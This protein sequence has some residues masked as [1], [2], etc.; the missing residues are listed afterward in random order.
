MTI[1]KHFDALTNR[2]LKVI[3]LRENSKVPMYRGWTENW[4]KDRVRAKL[5]QFPDANIGVLLG[6]VIDVEGDS[7][8]A[9]KLLLDLIGDY[10]HPCYQSARSTHHLFLPPSAELRHWE[11]NE[12]EF[13]GHGHQ[14]V[15]P[16]SRAAGIA[17]K[18]LRQFQFPVPPIPDRLLDFYMSKLEKPKKR[19]KLKKGHVKVWCSHCCEPVMLHRKRFDLELEA[20][21]LLGQKWEC[22]E[23]RVVDLRPACRLIRAGVPDRIIKVNALLEV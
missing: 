6:D 8:E 15:L 18:W 14:S 12:I 16:P 19:D 9:N 11:W 5:Q 21:K 1:L 4:D 3:P 23:C 17:Y 2:G 22:Q 7:E 20:F 13:R 10:P